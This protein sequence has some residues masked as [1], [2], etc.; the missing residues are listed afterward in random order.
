[1]SGIFQFISLVV[2]PL[3]A[4]ANLLTKRLESKCWEAMMNPESSLFEP[5]LVGLVTN[6]K[7][8]KNQNPKVG[9]TCQE[10]KKKNESV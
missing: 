6:K 2:F 10:T 7:N 4:Q 8:K 9:G 5:S 3:V 1:M